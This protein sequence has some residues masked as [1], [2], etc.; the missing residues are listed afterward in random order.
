MFKRINWIAL[1]RGNLD[2]L[3]LS[4]IFSVVVALPLSRGVP[5]GR[6]W[7]RYWHPLLEFLNITGAYWDVLWQGGGGVLIYADPSSFAFDPIYLLLSQWLHY[8]SNAVLYLCV[9]WLTAVMCFLL[10]MRALNVGLCER[11]IGT[12][13]YG[14]GGM[15]LCIGL[16]QFIP[17]YFHFPIFALTFLQFCRRGDRLRLFLAVG[18]AYYFLYTAVPNIAFLSLFG[19]LLILQGDYRKKLLL[20]CVCAVPLLIFPYGA[21]L[22]AYAAGSVAARSGWHLWSMHPSRLVA[23]FV[24]EFMQRN[25]ISVWWGNKYGVPGSYESYFFSLSLP[26]AALSGLTIFPLGMLGGFQLLGTLFFVASF[27]GCL[28]ARV[29]AALGHIPVFWVSYPEKYL[30]AAVPILLACAS[31]ALSRASDAQL[32]RAIIKIIFLSFIIIIATVL[33]VPRFS[34]YLQM[35]TLS[36][37]LLLMSQAVIMGIAL[38]GSRNGISYRPVSRGLLLFSVVPWLLVPYSDA[39]KVVDGFWLVKQERSEFYRIHKQRLQGQIFHFHQQATLDYC[40]EVYTEKY[41]T[42]CAE[43]DASF[44]F[45][46]T[47]YSPRHLISFGHFL[48]L[49]SNPYEE[50]VNFKPRYYVITKEARPR[51][52]CQT[53]VNNFP[54]IISCNI[55]TDS[56]YRGDLDLIEFAHKNTVSVH[57]DS[58]PQRLMINVFAQYDQIRVPFFP[59]AGAKVLLNGKDVPFSVDEFG[60]VI[61]AGKGTSLVEIVH[62]KRTLKILVLLSMLSA[63]CI[64]L[65]LYAMKKRGR[66]LWARTA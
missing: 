10:F 12:I 64:S 20:V 6:D 16:V 55:V 34:A 51:E 65:I 59:P 2:V 4:L 66:L 56:A 3:V 25:P 42:K 58:T 23:F 29:V 30:V 38:Y 14:F 9:V 39:R 21:L 36:V 40:H 48:R 26:L 37:K 61:K 41:M 24:P 50:I 47:N 54:S 15:G 49:A 27:I 52:F 43:Y 13:A 31:I 60:T 53:M 8:P 11:L 33:F 7:V 5:V 44:Y 18:S 1:S 19:A 32:R 46:L 57:P 62:T 45:K 17:I 35:L 63:V 28:P 22:E